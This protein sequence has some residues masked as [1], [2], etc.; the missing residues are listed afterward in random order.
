LT[1]TSAAAFADVQ[2]RYQ[3]DFNGPAASVPMIV[4][5]NGSITSSGGGSNAVQLQIFGN[6][7][8]INFNIGC[9][10]STSCT[11]TF[12]GQTVNDTVFFTGSVYTV[13]MS[14]VLDGGA[15]GGLAQ[16]QS[17]TMMGSI[18]PMFTVDL[19]NA[20]DFTFDFSSGLIPPASATP[21]P[22]ALPLFASGMAALGFLARRRKRK[23]AALAA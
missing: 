3:F 7:V 8:N 19:S 13:I 1:S 6:G 12:S 22:A 11:Q 21:L 17:Q 4:G 2:L 5:A 15:Q 20:S 10:G 18:D 9:F 14:I 23:A 16:D